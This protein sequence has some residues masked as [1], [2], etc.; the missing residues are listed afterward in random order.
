MHTFCL[1]HMH[2]QVHIL[3][4]IVGPEVINF[5]HTRIILLSIIISIIIMY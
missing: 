4:Q 1:V 2:M 3:F 5:E